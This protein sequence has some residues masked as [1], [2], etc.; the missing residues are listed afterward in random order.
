LESA[1][2]QYTAPSQLLAD[3]SPVWGELLV[4]DGELRMARLRELDRWL[5]DRWLMDEVL[6]MTAEAPSN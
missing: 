5:L 1:S 3:E 2:E 6:G 4:E